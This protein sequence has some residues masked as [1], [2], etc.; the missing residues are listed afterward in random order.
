[1]LCL[2][3]ISF[4]ENTCNTCFVF[5]IHFILGV[6]NRSQT[7]ASAPTFKCMDCP[8]PSKWVF[9]GGGHHLLSLQEF[10]MVQ[11]E[12][13]IQEASTRLDKCCK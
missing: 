9:L 3:W 5:I 10:F 11:L 4:V 6:Q 7:E 13:H 12:E 8:S 2:Y 1:M